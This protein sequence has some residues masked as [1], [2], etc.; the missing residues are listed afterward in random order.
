MKKQLNKIT[1]VI[2]CVFI[3]VFTLSS[4]SKEE[5]LDSSI[6]GTWSCSNR[7]YGGTDT[8]VFK[9]NGTY[10]WFYEGKADWF[11]DENGTYTYNGTILTVTKSS[12]YTSM[13]MVIGISKSSLV[14]MDDEGDKYT[15]YRK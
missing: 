9:K 15:Y 11:N 12:G 3:A 4:C 13:Y 1:K 7:Y 5:E 14:L 8:Y 2:L 10:S 6:V